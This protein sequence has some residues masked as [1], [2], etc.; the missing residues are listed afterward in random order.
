MVRARLH[1]NF[2]M[3]LLFAVNPGQAKELRTLRL[4]TKELAEQEIHKLAKSFPE[5]DNAIIF[6]SE[7]PVWLI[8]HGYKHHIKIR[9]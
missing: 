4:S 9:S 2:T 5:G 6:S 7:G 3:L 1:A 8:E